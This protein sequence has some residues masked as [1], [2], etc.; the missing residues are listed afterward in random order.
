M[1]LT[2]IFLKLFK[3]LLTRCKKYATL[4]NMKIVEALK[5]IQKE[6]NLKDGSFAKTLQTDRG[7]WN[8]IKNGRRKL[9]PRLILLAYQVYPQLREKILFSDATPQS[10]IATTGSTTDRSETTQN[11]KLA[12]FRGWA[13]VLILVLKRLFCNF[14]AKTD[15]K[16]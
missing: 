6:L 15:T 3:K 10:I 16:S 14:K 12:I 1:R 8:K 13:I 5:D 4:C 9:S 7:T 2:K 11:G